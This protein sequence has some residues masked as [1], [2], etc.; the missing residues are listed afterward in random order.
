MRLLYFELEYFHGCQQLVRS[1]DV[2]A[3]LIQ[4]LELGV[5]NSPFTPFV[6][7]IAQMFAHCGTIPKTAIFTWST[8]EPNK[9]L[10]FWLGSIG[11]FTNIVRFS[12]AI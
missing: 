2:C 12:V 5:R 3:G 8:K 4:G 11:Y 7:N 9:K 10:P 6:C 1:S